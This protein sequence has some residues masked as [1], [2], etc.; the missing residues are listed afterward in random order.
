V[1]T[2]KW[3]LSSFADDGNVGPLASHRVDDIE[4]IG[5]LIDARD[6]LFSGPLP[7]R[8]CS[9]VTDVSYV[10]VGACR[11]RLGDAFHLAVSHFRPP[12]EQ[13]CA[14]QLPNRSKLAWSSHREF[15]STLCIFADTTRPALLGAVFAILAV[16]T[17]ITRIGTRTRRRKQVCCGIYV[18]DER[19][20]S[21]LTKGRKKSILAHLSPSELE[22]TM[23][24]ERKMSH[25]YEFVKFL[26]SALASLSV[27][28]GPYVITAWRA[29]A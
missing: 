7:R 6:Y 18:K 5:A 16:L 17:S 25:F 10:L 29:A 22:L 15:L 3:N 9:R 4:S 14:Q 28:I 8:I 13:A 19:H 26:F 27:D 21:D 11:V 1:C 23:S 24:L 2:Q 20:H 12:S